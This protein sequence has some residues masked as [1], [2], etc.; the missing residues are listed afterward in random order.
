[1]DALN[2]LLV[3]DDRILVTTLSHGLRKAMGKT[4]SV[5]FCVSGDEALALL[6]TQVF[7]LV[8]SDFHMPGMSGLDL[9]K[10]VRH[11]HHA[12]N[13]VLITLFTSWV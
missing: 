3:D 7:N 6:A 4:V 10:Q 11:D 9:L 1:M 12:I 8:I 2:I 5:T 13:L